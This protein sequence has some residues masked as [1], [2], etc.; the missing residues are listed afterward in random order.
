MNESLKLDNAENRTNYSI[1]FHLNVW[2]W[3]I[4]QSN[5]E[6]APYTTPTYIRTSSY[7]KNG[8][9]VFIARSIRMIDI[10]NKI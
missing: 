10:I 2:I 1:V 6:D 8:A 4:Q 3:E 9:T 5:R 7:P